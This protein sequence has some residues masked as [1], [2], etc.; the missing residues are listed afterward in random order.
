MKKRFKRKTWF[1]IAQVMGVRSE[2]KNNKF[3]VFNYSTM[4][5]GP[6]R[7]TG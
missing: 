5:F 7:R 2:R 3:R 4:S 1:P 6:W